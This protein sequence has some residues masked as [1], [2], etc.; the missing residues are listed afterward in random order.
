[1]IRKVCA[2]VLIVL[3]FLPFTAPFSTCDTFDLGGGR[4]AAVVALVTVDHNDCA[5]SIVPP[6]QM[7]WGRLR[8]DV[9]PRCDTA[10]VYLPASLSSVA[11]L[12]DHAAPPDR[13]ALAA[14]PF[15]LRL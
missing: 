14:I 1:M 4:R 3:G 10:M 2:G 5:G 12:R 6:L 15:Q 13:S 8:P 11:R 9:S 7:R